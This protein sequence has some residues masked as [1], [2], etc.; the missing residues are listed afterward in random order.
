MTFD[1]KIQGQCT[2]ENQVRLAELIVEMDKSL[3]LW[4]QRGI[5]FM[6]LHQ[7]NFKPL[8]CSSNNK[9]TSQALSL[10]QRSYTGGLP[11]EER[12]SAH[13]FIETAYGHRLAHLETPKAASSWETDV[14]NIGWVV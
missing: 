3:R 7:H 8:Y 14:A 6:Q 13:N 5:S 1:L 4:P 11:P 10:T 2:Q 12:F 9:Y